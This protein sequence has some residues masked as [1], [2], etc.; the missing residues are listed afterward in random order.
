MRLTSLLLSIFSLQHTY[1]VTD[2]KQTSRVDE[3]L[4]VRERAAVPD[5]VLWRD[6][7]RRR[8]LMR[9]EIFPDIDE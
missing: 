6:E 2:H 4:S 5:E 7:E 3:G 8:K 9:N 1:L